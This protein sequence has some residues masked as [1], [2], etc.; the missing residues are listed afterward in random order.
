M[1]DSIVFS[2][3][4]FKK[5]LLNEFLIHTKTDTGWL[6]EYAKMFE[7]IMLKELGKLTP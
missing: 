1:A 4:C 3:S 6:A 2:N 5:K 7:L